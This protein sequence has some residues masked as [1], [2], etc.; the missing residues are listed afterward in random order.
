[1]ILGAKGYQTWK[2]KMILKL[3]EP[4]DTPEQAEERFKAF[5]SE[6]MRN[7]AFKSHKTNEGAIKA[8]Q[9]KLKRDP[10]FFK[11]TGHLGGIAKRKK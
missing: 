7:L 9:T 2:Q 8:A 6:R 5:N 4:G 11:K 10:D 1:M 3:S